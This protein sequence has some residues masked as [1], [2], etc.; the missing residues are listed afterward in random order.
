MRVQDI[1]LALRRRWYLGVATIVLAVA[2]T[3]LTVSLVGPT[4]EAKGAVLL[5][6]PG[7]TLQ[8]RPG[9]TTSAGN[10]YLELSGL[11]QARDIVI[12]SMS[13]KSTY[14]ELCE[15]TGDARYL[16]MRDDLCSANPSVSFEITQD[17]E[18]SAPV[19]LVTADA[20]SA[21]DA[22]TALTTV[23]DRVPSTLTELQGGLNLRPK[24]AITSTPIVADTLPDVLHKDQIR[25]AVL[26]GGGVLALGVL[27]IGVVD[28]LFLPRRRPSGTGV[29]PDATE[30]GA[31]EDGEPEDGAPAVEPTDAAP[32]EATPVS[33][34]VEPAPGPPAR[35]PG[36]KPAKPRAAGA[37]LGQ[38]G[39]RP[40]RRR[41]CR[42]IRPALGLSPVSQTLARTGGAPA[43][44]RPSPYTSVVPRPLG[45]GVRPD[46]LPRP[47]ARGPVGDGHVAARAA[48]AHRPRWSPSACSS[49]GRGSRCTARGGAGRAQPV[50]RAAPRVAGR[51]GRGLRPRHGGPAPG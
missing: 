27:L 30:D 42:P 31:L 34:E 6:P 49:S 13:A 4:Y 3:L 8:L 5:V 9:T 48:R 17:Y 28:G 43:R 22:V 50:R 36:R 16:S 10:P 37:G 18:S 24:A 7:N 32:G 15:A 51:D 26:V 19:I 40:A 12:R 33:P 29:D 14:I 39:R 41:R 47:A 25:A 46:R 23:M 20:G 38:P 2:A 35:R 44:P 21:Q 1:L 11:G 45:R